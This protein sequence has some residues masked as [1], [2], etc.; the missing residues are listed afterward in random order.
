VKASLNIGAGGLRIGDRITFPQPAGSP[1]V[2]P[3]TGREVIGEPQPVGIHQVDVRTR[4][5]AG[6]ETTERFLRDAGCLVSR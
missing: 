3:S 6:H 4:D 2:G 5:G 1:V